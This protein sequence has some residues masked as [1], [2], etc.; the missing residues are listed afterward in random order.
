M[1]KN[2][3]RYR[4]YY[5]DKETGF[6]YLKSRYYNP[7][8][9]RFLNADGLV[10]TGQGVT[11]YNMFAYCLNNP[12]TG[13]DPTGMCVFDVMGTWHCNSSRCKTSPNY[14]P[15]VHDV[16]GTYYPAPSYSPPAAPKPAPAPAPYTPGL[17]SYNDPIKRENAPLPAG[18]YTVGDGYGKRST[19][20]SKASSFHKGVDL[21]APEW[22]PIYA[23]EAGTAIAFRDSDSGGYGNCVRIEWDNMS[24]MN[25]HMITPAIPYGIEVSVDKGQVIGYVGSTGNSSVNHLHFE[26]RINGV[27]VSN[28]QDYMW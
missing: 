12:V 24:S 18:S 26:I 13:W 3:I 1:Q 8:V 22:T 20:F 23:V 10:S 25:G 17:P 15:P 16:S 5:F 4:G 11:G 14:I 2:P 19:T 28:P 27:A 7:E 21:F 6:Y 9:K